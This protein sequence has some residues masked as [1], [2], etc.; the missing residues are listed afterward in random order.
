[1]LIDSVGLTVVDPLVVVTSDDLDSPGHPTE[2]VDWVAAD[3]LDARLA[4]WS[5]EWTEISDDVTGDRFG[6]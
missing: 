4:D 1:M 2:Q 3:E 6:P 5:I